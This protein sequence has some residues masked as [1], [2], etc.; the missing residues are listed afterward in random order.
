MTPRQLLSPQA[1]AALFDPPREI[2]AI[3]RHYTFSREE[4]TRIRQRRREANRL[5]FAV[6][7][8]LNRGLRRFTVL[9]S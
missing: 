9:E 1:R 7:L 3:V 4:L 8:Y 6:G 2:R 5:G